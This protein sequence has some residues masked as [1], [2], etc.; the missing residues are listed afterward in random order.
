MHDFRVSSNLSIS[1]NKKAPRL[2]CF[3]IGGG[4]LTSAEGT[5]A[6][7]SV[8]SA[9]GGGRSEQKRVTKQGE[10]RRKEQGDYVLEVRSREAARGSLHLRQQKRTFCLPKVP[11]CLSEAYP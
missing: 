5:G 8:A 6:R 1:A 2:R 3:F 10:L 4:A 11:F 7:G 9:A